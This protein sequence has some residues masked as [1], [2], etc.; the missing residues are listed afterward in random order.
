MDTERTTHWKRGLM[1]LALITAALIGFIGTAEAAPLLGAHRG[2]QW[3]GTYT[4]DS[5]LAIQAAI[6]DPDATFVE[7]DIWLTS[8]GQ[9]FMLHDATLDRVTNCTG[10]INAHPLAWLQANCRFDDGSVPMSAVE[11][12]QMMV[13]AHKHGWIHVKSTTN[14]SSDEV[15]RVMNAVPGSKSYLRLMVRSLNQVT[16]LRAH[17][18]GAYYEVATGAPTT[19]I[20]VAKVKAAG[21]RIMVVPAAYTGAAPTSIITPW[22][23]HG[24]HV[25]YVTYNHEQDVQAGQ[26]PFER[27]LSG[28][29]P[30]TKTTLG[31]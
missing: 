19:A 16:Y 14:V 23:G 21:V 6:N 30:A 5:R 8:D 26:Y 10:P 1:L 3:P 7:D 12:A 18:S 29:I 27:V 15:V 11:Y 28:N 31:I 17:M 4:E 20:S 24:L 2:E 13:A 25:D 22:F 9:G